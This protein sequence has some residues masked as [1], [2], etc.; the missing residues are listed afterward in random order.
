LSYKWVEWGIVDD[1]QLTE[2]RDKNL[3]EHHVLVIDA[4]D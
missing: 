4:P 2:T 3:A 1:E